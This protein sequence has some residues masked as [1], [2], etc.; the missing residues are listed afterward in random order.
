MSTNIDNDGFIEVCKSRKSNC[1]SSKPKR[2]TKTNKQHDGKNGKLLPQLSISAIHNAIASNSFEAV[3][4]DIITLPYFIKAQ[5]KKFTGWIYDYIND[6]P[7]VSKSIYTAEHVKTMFDFTENK[8]VWKYKINEYEMPVYAPWIEIDSSGNLINHNDGTGMFRKYSNKYFMLNNSQL[9]LNS[10]DHTWNID[11]WLSILEK[12]NVN[13][14]NISLINLLSALYIELVRSYS[15]MYKKNQRADLY[16]TIKK[17][18]E[19]IFNY[20]KSN[21]LKFMDYNNYSSWPLNVK[22]AMDAITEGEIE[23]YQGANKFYKINIHN[24]SCETPEMMIKYI[25]RLVYKAKEINEMPKTSHD[26]LYL[27]KSPASEK[28]FNIDDQ[29]NSMIIKL[30][31]N[32]LCTPKEININ[33]DTTGKIGNT[34]HVLIQ[35]KIGI[36]TKI[37]KYII[38][39]D[40]NTEDSISK[41]K[42]FCMLWNILNNSET[43]ICESYCNVTF[44]DVDYTNPKNIYN[45]IE[46]AQTNLKDLINIIGLDLLTSLQNSINIELPKDIIYNLEEF[47][48]SITTNKFKAIDILEHAPHEFKKWYAYIVL[49]DNT[50]IPF[51]YNFTPIKL[52]KQYGFEEIELSKQLTLNTGYNIIRNELI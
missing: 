24:I 30:I 13:I 23:F 1:K 33:L 12:C 5:N 45:V 15:S 37:F 26:D 52:F 32:I 29:N 27:S 38:G 47:V 2:T 4:N 17:Y 25:I 44:E 20:M 49:K 9:S 35:N 39:I 43:D 22:K 51:K 6:H 42:R 8:K 10:L 36:F 28:Y 21:N 31:Y 40:K 46:L 16:T 34:V 19:S 14:Y 7:D 18:N 48:N 11:L 3:V 50:D 41:I